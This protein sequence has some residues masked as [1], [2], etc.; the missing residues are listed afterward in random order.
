M[1]EIEKVSKKLNTVSELLQQNMSIVDSLIDEV[2]ELKKTDE[3]KPLYI[4][5][6]SR[7]GGVSVIVSS[8][9]TQSRHTFVSWEAAFNEIKLIEEFTEN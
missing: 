3:V 8:D 9:N 6:E 1:N 7:K 2:A 4:T 5:M